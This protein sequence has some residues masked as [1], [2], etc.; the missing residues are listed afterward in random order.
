MA[1]LDMTLALISDT[2]D[3]DIAEKIAE[4]IGYSSCCLE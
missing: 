1:A 3:I 4:D 2:L